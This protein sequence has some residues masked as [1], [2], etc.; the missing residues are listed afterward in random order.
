MA[1]RR[2]LKILQSQTAYSATD[3]SHTT[4]D[5]EISASGWKLVFK[6]SQG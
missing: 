2:A 5:L 1:C 3:G 6:R 4:G